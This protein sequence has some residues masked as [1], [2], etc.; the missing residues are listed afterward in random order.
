[1]KYFKIKLAIRNLLRNKFYS[2]IN[3][4]GLAIGIAACVLILLYVRFETSYDKFHENADRIYRVNLFAALSNDEFNTP[5][6][7][8]PLAEAMEENI[9]EVEEAVR[10][11][12]ADQPVIKHD[13][14]IFNEKKWY[15]TDPDF[16]KVFSTE[17]IF[18]NPSQALT[19]PNSVVLTESSANKYFGA[20]NP[21]GKYITKENDRDYLVTGVIR[22]FPLNSHIK[23]NFLASIV[24]QPVI[25]NP[26]WTNNM[27]YTYFLLQDGYSKADIDKELEKIVENFV[28]PEVRR[29]MGISFEDLKAQGAKYQ[30][31]AQP[32][33]DVH[34][35][36]KLMTD[37]EPSGNRSYMIIFSIIAVFILAIACINFMNMSTA[38][39]ANRAKEVGIRKSLGSNKKYLVSQFISESVFVTLISLVFAVVLIKILLPGFSNLVGQQL[40]FNL[41][42]NVSTIPL[43]LGLGI[44]VGIIAGI[45]P[46]FFLASFSPVKVI[47]GM[48]KSGG[49]HVRLRNGLVIFQLAIS[50]LLFSGTF[51]ISKQLNF[52]QNKELGFNKENLVVI[53][54]VDN[55]KAKVSSLKNELLA[56]S[57]I[58]AVTNTSAIPG[59]FATSSTFFYESASDPRGIQTLWTDPDFIKTFEIEMVEGRY[60]DPTVQSNDHSVVL[61]ESAV[62]KL[63]I[64]D[65]V[66]KKIF[67]GQHSD[68][69]GYTIIGVMKDFHSQSLHKEISSIVVREGVE[70]AVF[71][72][73]LVVRISSENIQQNLKQMEQIWSKHASGEDFSYVFFDEDF[74]R[75]YNAEV[76]TR[77]IVTIFSALAI[78]IACLG[79]LALAAFVAEQRTKEIGVRKV[80]GARVSEILLSLNSG[81]MKR[82]GIAFV[83]AVPGAWYLLH[84]WLRNFAYQTDL[85]WWTFALAGAVALLL[86][87]ITV[88]WISWKAATRNPI[89]ALRYE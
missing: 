64:E 57:G 74:G 55:L 29:S 47:K 36:N 4:L 35:D 76:R 65:P 60:F 39:S 89:E 5:T 25:K 81:F 21:V 56:Q 88:S 73:N 62:E 75:L 20:E 63:N 84:N 68:E 30:L 3:I 22:D 42:S 44:F 46:A 86:T 2:L 71:G 58:S 80:N 45:Y 72:N 85:S 66:G 50:I 13:N 27:L 23:P 33:A 1:M 11:I 19:Q 8:V 59:R 54:N 61:N 6:T 41:F 10:I 31:Y 14:I 28:G 70:K 53:Q 15:F 79:L 9:P 51:V 48:N 32:I 12:E 78:I 7:S 24:A 37:L 26:R 16:F 52:L 18:G 38:R 67:E 34:F 83:V 40:N 82:V 49:V 43:L 69:F 17:F 77:K 87:I